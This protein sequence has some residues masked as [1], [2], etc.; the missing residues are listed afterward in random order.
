MTR[1]IS[2]CLL[3]A[4]VVFVF[5]LFLYWLGSAK[6]CIPQDVCET[7]WHQ[8]LKAPANEV[9]DTLAGVFGAFAFPM[10]M[11]AVFLQAREL[12]Q[13][14]EEARKTA[15]ALTERTQLEN[16]SENGEYF[17]ELIVAIA[18]NSEL[19]E[20]HWQF[21][22][23]SSVSTLGRNLK[24]NLGF[25]KET[26]ENVDS[27]LTDLAIHLNHVANTLDEN[28]ANYQL[29]DDPRVWSGYKPTSLLQYARKAVSLRAELSPA[30]QQRL[31]NLKLPLLTTALE[32]IVQNERLWVQ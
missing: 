9:G 8:F 18:H 22:D 28:L 21:E 25:V 31:I 5:A 16:R 32:R 11:L 1:R 10:A 19:A 3:F 2:F 26:H 12:R 20:V 14:S 4:S 13:A 29:P 17:E 15:D 27:T 23:T 30:K 6:L 7:R 24:V